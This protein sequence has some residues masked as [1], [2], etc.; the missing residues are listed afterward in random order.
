M[1]KGLPLWQFDAD[2]PNGVIDGL[3]HVLQALK[4]SNLAKARWLQ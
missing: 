2:A 3:A 4:V 1:E